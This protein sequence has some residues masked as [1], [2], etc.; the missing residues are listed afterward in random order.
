MWRYANEKEPSDSMN[1]NMG[2]YGYILISDIKPPLPFY[3]SHLPS[4]TW[5]FM[6]IF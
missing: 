6:G 1:K 4:K 5:V 3:I 2:V